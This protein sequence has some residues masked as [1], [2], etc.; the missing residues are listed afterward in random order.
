DNPDPVMQGFNLMLTA[1]NV[2]DSDGTITRVEFYRD[3][4]NN[5]VLDVGVDNLLTI[6]TK[7]ADGW[8]WFGSTSGFPIT[9]ITYFARA[10]DNDNAWSNIHSATSTIERF[11]V[12]AG[13]QNTKTVKYADPDG[14]NVTLKLNNGSG[15]LV[16]DGNSL[17]REIKGSTMTI[18]GSAELIDV[19][20]QNSNAKT[21][22]T[23][24]AKNG[25]G[26]TTLGGLSGH[27][28]GKITGKNLDL[29]GDIDLNGSLNAL[30]LDDIASHVSVTT[31]AP[32]AAGM[33]IK[34]D[35]INDQVIFDL[36]DSVKNFQA[37][38]FDSGSLTT[39]FIQT[40]KIKQ[41]P[42]GANVTTQSGGINN[43]F[44]Y[45]TILGNINSATFINKITSKIGGVSF[46][47]NI[48]AN[49]GDIQ[50]I[51]TSQTIAGRIM[52]HN[53]ILNI[54]AKSG[55][56]TG[57]AHAK[58]NIG[59]INAGDFQ[60]A[61]ISAGQDINQINAAGHINDTFFMA[62][63]DFSAGNTL[64]L[65]DGSINKI[66]AGG[67]FSGSYISAAVLPPVNELLSVLPGVQPPYTGLGYLGNIGKVTFGA[68]LDQNATTDF[69]LYASGGI[70][71]IKAGNMIYTQSDPQINFRVESFLG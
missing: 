1:N 30:T 35:H 38:S 56:F 7:N 51:T 17:R 27:T 6:D 48:T 67:S 21:S 70:N 29:I 28:L 65:G 10:Q 20:L 60:G 44:A 71:P 61:V 16:F 23:I 31:N 26:Q 68:A 34:I 4:N 40:L 25:D 15:K 2:Q 43:L 14:S 32:S 41:G 50:K 19:Q 45:N 52:S 47:S 42:L 24:N 9:D 55:G 33:K 11:S 13:L 5:G 46:A 59:K 36:D 22:L 39:D 62:G 54:S 66:S 53:S 63:Y 37:N 8:F 18:I 69:G 58:E 64:G 57:E 3:A 49:A 12:T